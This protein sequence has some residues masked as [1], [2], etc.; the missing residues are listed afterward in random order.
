[1]LVSVWFSCT[2]EDFNSEVLCVL[3]GERHGLW[4]P[5]SEEVRAP[6]AVQRSCKGRFVKGVII[7]PFSGPEVVPF[8]V[9]LAKDGS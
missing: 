9:V 5:E 6:D 1:M 7:W 8:I 2:Q 3:K 4:C